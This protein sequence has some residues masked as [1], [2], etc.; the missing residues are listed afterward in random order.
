MS[1]MSIINSHRNK[2]YCYL[3]NDP[4][5]TDP[6]EYFIPG[7]TSVPVIRDNYVMARPKQ[8]FDD[9]RKAITHIDIDESDESLDCFLLMLFSNEIFSINIYDHEQIISLIDKGIEKFNYIGLIVHLT[10]RLE[11]NGV[12][13]L[14]Y[15]RFFNSDMKAYMFYNELSSTLV[16]SKDDSRSSFNAFQ[17]LID[18][19]SITDHFS[20]D[21]YKKTVYRIDD[22]IY[23]DVI[24]NSDLKDVLTP[25]VVAYDEFGVLYTDYYYNS[26]LVS[27]DILNAIDPF[28]NE[29]IVDFYY[30]T[31]EEVKALEM[32]LL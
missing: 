27:T 11:D 6:P 15:K 9:R 21:T 8:S 25:L 2:H 10:F 12:Y 4:N 30:L 1:L 23:I 24:V 31:P 18:G 16:V 13:L 7:A 14:K 20:N 17:R 3:E 29:K 5:A 22:R 19:F 26:K 28:F 32:L